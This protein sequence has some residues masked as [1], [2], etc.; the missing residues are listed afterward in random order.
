MLWKLHLLTPASLAV[1]GTFC[2]LCPVA[3]QITVTLE[4]QAGSANMTL[5][6]SGG[7]TFTSA[8][9]SS[10]GNFTHGSATVVNSSHASLGGE[11]KELLFDGNATGN[12]FAAGLNGGLA[13]GQYVPLDTAISGWTAS[14]DN[15]GSG[16][17]GNPAPSPFSIIGILFTEQNNSDNFGLVTDQTQ[18]DV[19]A[20]G[21]TFDY[22]G[23]SATSST[24]TLSA[25]TFDNFNLGD[26]TLD[27]DFG[28]SP[29]TS[30]LS[31]TAV[32]EPAE[33]AI[34][35]GVILVCAVYWR[36][37]RLSASPLVLTASQ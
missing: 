15:T 27:A 24:F 7:G 8:S 16:G 13:D 6:F 31:I 18:G 21:I 33:Y 34:A 9:S 10:P 29:G 37:R 3:A 26:Y 11:S 30:T 28:N 36:R 23:G 1:I 17:A 2:F 22:S 19:W 12:P 20:S 32:P 5:R 25:G 14:G 4:G 35:T